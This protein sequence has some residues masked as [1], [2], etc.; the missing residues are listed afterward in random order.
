MHLANVRLVLNP[1]LGTVPLHL[2]LR[3]QAQTVII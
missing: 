1:S 3:T 2:A